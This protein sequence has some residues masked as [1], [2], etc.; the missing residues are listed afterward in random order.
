MKHKIW[1]V[2]TRKL[3]WWIASHDLLY[4]MNLYAMNLNAMNGKPILVEVGN[5]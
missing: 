5:F 3:H 4:A 2:A 1:I